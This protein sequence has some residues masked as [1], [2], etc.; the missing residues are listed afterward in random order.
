MRISPRTIFT[1][2]VMVG[3][4]TV[5]LAACGSAATTS[6]T[7]V[8]AGSAPATSSTTSSQTTTSAPTTS[9]STTSTST[10][11]ST[12]AAVAGPAPC[13]A[14]GL[15]LSF[16]GGQGATGH[17]A[18]GF[19]LRNTQS[20][21]CRTYGYPG[22]EFLTQSGAPVPTTA[23]R[24]TSDFFGTTKLA[25][26]VLAPGQTASFRLSVSHGAASTAGCATAYGLQAIPPDDTAILIA[27]IPNGAYECGPVTVSPVMPGRSAY[28]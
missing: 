20:A 12:T 7:P 17:G 28:P 2:L 18:L 15:E 14:A 26:L 8:A 25:P 19:A 23:A 22:V 1:R 6:S 4:A 16:L 3:A 10:S 9:T 13:R 24:S 27:S 11:T 5:L 21:S